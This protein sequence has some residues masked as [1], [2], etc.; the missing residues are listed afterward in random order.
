[1]TFSFNAR[2]YSM[3]TGEP[4]SSIPR[5]SIRPPC[6]LPVEYSE[7]H[8]PYAQEGIQI[9]LNLILQGLFDSGGT[10]LQFRHIA[11]VDSE[12]FGCHS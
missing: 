11:I 5:V 7:A 3:M 2:L 1:M 9:R 4:S 10:P 6:F 8:H 12:K